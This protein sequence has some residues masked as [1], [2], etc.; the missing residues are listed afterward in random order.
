M[1]RLISEETS[2]WAVVMAARADATSDGGS[3]P[4]I[5]E[6]TN[7]ALQVLASHGKRI[8]D[9]SAG[10][11]ITVALYF[12]PTDQV[13]APYR[14]HMGQ[15]DTEDPS[16]LWTNWVNIYGASNAP[17]QRVVIQVSVAQLEGINGGGADAL[18]R[19]AAIHRY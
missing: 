4:G 7:A 15:G 17:P 9:L 1:A 19:A 10:E 18:K 14:I 3:M 6:A 5:D 11:P 8:R 16:M 2:V 13:T 12:T